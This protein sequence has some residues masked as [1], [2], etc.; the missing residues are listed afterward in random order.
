[1]SLEQIDDAPLPE[2]PAREDPLASATPSGTVSPADSDPPGTP[3]TVPEDADDALHDNED[4][5]YQLMSIHIDQPIGSMSISPANR[6]VALGSRTGLYIVDLQ[7][8]YDPPRFLPH[9]SAWEVSDVQWNPFPARSEWVCSTSNQQAVVYNLSLSPALSASPIEHALY[10]HRRAV[11]D[12]NWSPGSPEVLATS[13]MDGWVMAWD[14]R[15]GYGSTGR[16]RKPIWRVSTWDSPATQVKFN[17]HE[18]HMIAS[19][20]GNV[21]HIWDDRMG[22]TPVETVGG[23]SARIY[24]IDWCRKDP[25]Q[26][27]TCSLDS[28]FK[29]WRIDS[30]AEPLRSV[31]TSSPIWRAR[32]LPFGD[33]ILTLPQR[34]DH[35]LS[36]WSVKS[37]DDALRQ[38]EQ[39]EACARFEGAR[40]G[41]KEFVWRTRGGED[42]ES[43]DREF[44]LVTWAKDR[45][46]RLWPISEALTKDVGHVKGS[47]IEVPM[48]RR[49]G[50]DISYRSFGEAPAPVGPSLDGTATVQATSPN[51]ASGSLLSNVLASPPAPSLLTSS[52]LNANLPNTSANKEHFVPHPITSAVRAESATMTTAKVTTRRQKEHD[53]LAWMEGVKVLRAPEEIEEPETEPVGQSERPGSVVAPTQPQTRASSVVRGGADTD[54][55]TAREGEDTER[56]ESIMSRE[57]L[58]TGT[59]VG[60]NAEYAT[61]GEEVTSVVR[62]FPRVNFEK[63]HVAGRSCTVSLYSPLFIRATFNFPR[64]YPATA[65]PTIELE[66]SV[67]LTLKQRASILQGVRRLMALRAE[68][69][70]PSFEQAL[71][72]LSGDRSVEHIEEE[73]E[74]D[75]DAEDGLQ[76]LGPMSLGADIL[77]NNINV[78][79][80]RR[81]GA[82]FGPSG[83]L[84]VFFPTDVTVE[85]DDDDFTDSPAEEADSGRRSFPLRVSDA[86]GSIAEP[87]QG[88]EYQETDE[89]LQLSTLG[90]I[91]RAQ[92]RDQSR[93]RRP[94]TPAAVSAFSTVVKIKDVSH[95][96]LVRPDRSRCSLTKP[97]LDIAR[98]SALGAIE[99]NDLLLA[100]IWTT[101]LASFES[102]VGDRKSGSAA[103]LESLTAENILQEALK[104][105]ASLRDVQTLGIVACMLEM[106][107]RDV[108]ENVR[109]H[110]AARASEDYFSQRHRPIDPINVVEGGS[111]ERTPLPTTASL[112]RRRSD[113]SRSPRPSWANLT[114]LFN[115]GMLSL[116]STSPASPPPAP[117]SRLGPRAPPPSGNNS[118]LTPS[119]RPPKSPL[120]TSTTA[121]TTPVNYAHSQHRPGV[122]FGG[123]SVAVLPPKL[124]TDGEPSSRPAAARKQVQI[125]F[126]ETPHYPT[127]WW[128][129]PRAQADLEMIR[130]AYA[131]LL[132]RWGM[133]LERAQVLKLCRSATGDER[134][135][136]GLA[137]TLLKEANGLGVET[138]IEAPRCC[139]GCGAVLQQGIRSCARCHRRLHSVRCVLCH[140][141][142]QGLT[143][144]C[145]SCR[146]LG[147]LDC[148]AS[149]FS[150]NDACPTGCGCNCVGDGGTSGLFPLA[151]SRFGQSIAPPAA[152]APTVRSRPTRVITP[153][154]AAASRES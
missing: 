45:R 84:L 101:I 72:F 140:Q 150:S 135:R 39:P 98:E 50:P 118:P 69:G 19:A 25:K 154:W 100:K 74:E 47:R 79:P 59:A 83:Q 15:T 51:L 60:K 73:E 40:E 141:P 126:A 18:A 99:A 66:R 77:R 16:G 96:T 120:R 142:V 107:T 35:A 106:C 93:R 63:I 113:P 151:P 26:L 86:F 1:M 11:T 125:A 38:G 102:G 28:S 115:S 92:S 71:R 56:A 117:S 91:R 21:V 136:H 131:E 32:W 108:E 2:N 52:I 82:C 97:L 4:T 149:W 103:P 145:A 46:L 89:A 42:P 55:A 146:H 58:Q 43:D 111:G 128:L 123:T 80:P 65:P 64:T 143:Q 148:L 114:G 81:G 53:R 90:G 14:L 44:Q 5:F 147:H 41:V 133:N 23:H 61:L 9:A 27:V 49:G 153:S 121:S 34:S 20:H 78:P 88:G 119:P 112:V 30:L 8:P 116:R 85:V 37:I 48:T 54:A 132:Y 127:C 104:F 122:T 110:Q 144:S 29:S 129:S 36:I 22:A 7:N 33:G 75:D 12:I 109:V 62:R 105:L 68:R 139:V 3:L 70:S 134:S 6:D 130:L 13:A 138:G 67:D 76:G 124:S 24:G 17:R 87:D 10:G 95:L 137:A 152:T 94:T 57:S 31:T